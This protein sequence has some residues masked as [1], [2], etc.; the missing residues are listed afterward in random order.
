MTIGLSTPTD[1]ADKRFLVLTGFKPDAALLPEN[2]LQP[3]AY[4][5]NIAE[6]ASRANT[7]VVLPTG[8]GKTMVAM[9]VAKARLEKFPK[10]KVVMLAPTKPLVQQHY[11][12]FKRMM[13]IK[14]NE[15]AIMTGET[16]PE[17]RSYLWR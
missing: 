11:E 14:E 5:Q 15:I 12:T 2:T 7:L 9:L 16:H 13:G 8:L 17:E 10:G 1:Q 4:Q 3:R 6:A